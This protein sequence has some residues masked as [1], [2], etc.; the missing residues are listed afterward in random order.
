MTSITRILVQHDAELMAQECGA[1][2]GDYEI[3]VKFHAIDETDP[4]GGI[5]PSASGA[6]GFTLPAGAADDDE[7]GAADAEAVGQ[8]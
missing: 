8:D 4:Y 6:M 1:E 7:P 5:I 2:A 3:N